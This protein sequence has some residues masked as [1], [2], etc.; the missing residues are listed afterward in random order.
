MHIL[1]I[2][3]FI[4]LSSLGFS[5]LK[6]LIFLKDK[7]I[8]KSEVLKKTSDAYLTALGE[9]TE[10]SIERRK[11][12]M[13]ENIITYED[14]PL[15]EPYIKKIEDMGIKIEN[16]LKWFNAVS[17]Y[18]NESQL[19]ALQQYEFI[20]KI[21]LVRKHKN[22]RI[23][24]TDALNKILSTYGTISYGPSLPQLQ[25]S[26]IPQ[27][28]AKD[29]TGKGVVVGLLDAGFAW[30]THEAL[31]NAHVISEYDFV[32]QDSVTS[33]EPADVPGQHSHGAS[34]FS[35]IGGYKDSIL[36]GA[37]F[38]ASFI[39]AKTE[40]IRSEK[41]VEEDNYAAALEWMESIGVDIT[42]SSLGY[43]EF[44]SPE[45]SYTYQDMNGKTTIVTKA[46]ELAFQRGIVTITS[47]GNEGNKAWYYI[48]APADGFNTIGVGAVTANNNVASFSGR[49]PTSDGRIKPDVLAQGVNV[50]IATSSGKNSYNYG[51]GTSLSA[52]IVSGTAALL[53]S[54]YPHLSNSQIRHILLETSDNASIPDN[55]RG[56]GLVSAAKAISYPNLRKDNNIVRLNKAFIL[57]GSVEQS[58]IKIHYSI[59]SSAFVS[60]PMNFDSDYNCYFDLPSLKKTDDFRFYFTY[61]DSAGN[62]YLEPEKGKHYLLKQEDL[63]VYLNLKYIETTADYILSPNY[64]NPFNQ[65]TRI[66]FFA[67]AGQQTELIVYDVLGQRVKYLFGGVSSAGKNTVLWD[68]SNDNGIK[69]AS[70]V[71]L[72]I[73]RLD[74]KEYGRSMVL[75]R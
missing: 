11:K 21:R 31:Q 17:A 41:H 1:I 18:L 34:V 19:Q 3:F 71:Y 16:K 10:R 70:G 58:S 74:G 7:G 14:V 37:A 55:D 9:L 42:S 4:L 30:R 72:Y 51:N 66:D 75:L 15:Y 39:L 49:G 61:S 2:A 43:S 64:P 62:G 12:A 33:D 68:G 67:E 24:T 40:D 23:E 6:Y 56:Y 69:A 63:N 5:Q 48:T 36:I 32:F 54:A 46:A 26:D 29:I 50:L 44:D 27:V 65:Q 28:H 45:E 13:G 60:Y 8:N 57:A 22:G 52:P 73:L 53:L 35:I 25:L 59:N 47:A 20:E 38:G